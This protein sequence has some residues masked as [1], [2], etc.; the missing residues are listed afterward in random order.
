M[1]NRT[2]EFRQSVEEKKKALPEGKRRR[3]TRPPRRPL[4]DREGE[5]NA[6]ISSK[7]YVAEAYTI[8]SRVKA[9][10]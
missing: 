5:Q 7:D 10:H 9:R 8:V 4:K 2:V 1:S 6:L 3:I